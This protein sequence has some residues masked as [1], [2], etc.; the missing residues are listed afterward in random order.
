MTLN[1]TIKTVVGNPMR[2]VKIPKAPSGPETHAY[3]IEE[4]GGILAAL[5]AL[6]D[7]LP[8]SPEKGHISPAV[9][10]AI[11]ATAAFTGLRRSELRGLRWED[12]SGS[13]LAIRR[14]AWEL[15]VESTKTEDSEATVPVIGI[16]A[17]T[18]N[19]WR[20]RSGDP[21]AGYMF[22]SSKG[23]P[24]NI[25]NLEKR[26][27]RP[28][29]RKAGIAW[30]GWHAFRRGLGTNLHAMGVDDLTIQRILRHSNV[31]I[32]QAYYIK[33]APASAVA[34]MQLFEAQA[35]ALCANCAQTFANRPVALLQ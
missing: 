35:S 24:L 29:L 3:S 1:G 5:L 27:I 17:Q 2:G 16:L 28:T 20:V 25:N 7:G 30:Y 8:C 6:D 34:A 21:S 33:T 18:L 14:S 31:A 15:H 10:F 32:T 19:T 11:A 22:A 4:I 12:Y 23:T 13:G 26:V 9:A